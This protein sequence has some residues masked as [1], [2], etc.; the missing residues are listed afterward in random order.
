MA[1]YSFEMADGT[2]ICKQLP[3]FLL[4]D[5][6][7]LKTLLVQSCLVSAAL[8]MLCVVRRA[9]TIEQ[10]TCACQIT[11]ESYI[12]TLIPLNYIPSTANDCYEDNSLPANGS[13]YEYILE[14]A[15]QRLPSTNTQTSNI[16]NMADCTTSLTDTTTHQR[17]ENM[18]PVLTA[19][20]GSPEHPVA[21]ADDFDKWMEM[22][23][24]WSWYQVCHPKILD[25]HLL[26]SIEVVSR[27]EIH[28][29]GENGR[30]GK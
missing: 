27:N 8:I 6:H 21:L 26:I 10:L 2:S 20:P 23:R 16:S 3:T 9:K 25:I 15:L 1:G 19:R 5:H 28:D 11:F 4:H 7:S 22:R 17:P 18:F 24:L 14:S 12:Q 29:Q 30:R 13:A